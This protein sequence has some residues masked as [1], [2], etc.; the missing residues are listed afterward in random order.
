MGPALNRESRPPAARDATDALAS[1]AA[2]CAA[3]A[4][5]PDA[6][7]GA[8][9]G[10]REPRS[11]R[12]GV[13]DFRR[14]WNALRALAGLEA[15]RAG[16]RFR[17]GARR[18]ALGVWLL[19][20]LLAATAAAAALLLFGAASALSELA[21]GRWWAGA[22]G[23]GVAFFAVV[24]FLLA[25]RREGCAPRARRTDGLSCNVADPRPADRPTE[26]P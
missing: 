21:G 7:D 1:A 5:R 8:P 22:L 14:L 12:R 18:A 3:A 24:A 9:R 13:F 10:A 4:F 6:T 2:A 25:P 19:T 20:A 26:T 23:V 17:A 15:A 11:G 16:R